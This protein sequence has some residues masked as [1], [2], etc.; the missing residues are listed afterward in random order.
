MYPG[1][2]IISIKIGLNYYFVFVYIFCYPFTIDKYFQHF[3]SH[4]F[5]FDC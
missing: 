3:Q 2:A 5:L 1:N 4:T